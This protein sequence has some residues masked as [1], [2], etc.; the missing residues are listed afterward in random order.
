MIENNSTES[1]VQR[2]LPSAFLA[3]TPRA[4]KVTLIRTES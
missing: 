4:V 3:A 2:P 1:N